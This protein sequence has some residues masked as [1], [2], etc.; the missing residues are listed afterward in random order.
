M[1]MFT[2]AN[3]YKVVIL[4]VVLNVHDPFKVMIKMYHHIIA[5]NVPFYLVQCKSKFTVHC[6]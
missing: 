4:S 5:R 6:S 2:E 1:S 3:E